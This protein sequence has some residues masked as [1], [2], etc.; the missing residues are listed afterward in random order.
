MWVAPFD[1]STLDIT[2]A[3]V[4]VLQSRR[5]LSSLLSHDMLVSIS[6]AHLPN[7]CMQRHFKGSS[8]HLAVLIV[9]L[10]TEKLAGKEL[11]ATLYEDMLNRIARRTEIIA[12]ISRTQRHTRKRRRH[13]VALLRCVPG[14]YCSSGPWSTDA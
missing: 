11:L 10:L 12:T 6:V 9:F 5:K 13:L 8:S 14:S 4:R 2:I 1:M 7:K 3:I